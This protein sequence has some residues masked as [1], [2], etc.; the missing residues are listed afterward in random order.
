[1]LDKLMSYCEMLHDYE[2]SLSY[3]KRIVCFDRARE[4]THRNLMRLYYLI[5]DR[6]EALRQYERCAVA[7]SE[8]L[9]LPPSKNTIA[10][11][12]EIQADQF[13][14]L[15][16]I[17]VGVAT[18]PEAPVSQLLEFLD[19]LSHLQSSLNDLQNEVHRAIRL[20]S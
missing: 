3:G 14:A 16:S 7:L 9:G 1:M 15:T 5:G 2:T 8:E 4:R 17:P 12:R 18:S 6:E 11:Y 19:H 10:L 13:D 20:Y